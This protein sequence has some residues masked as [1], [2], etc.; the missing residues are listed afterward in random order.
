MS[1]VPEEILPKTSH[2]DLA[3]S[4]ASPVVGI[5][6]QYGM[7]DNALFF[8]GPS[9]TAVESD[10]LFSMTSGTNIFGFGS[11]FSEDSLVFR[12]GFGEKDLFTARFSTGLVNSEQFGGLANA[13]AAIGFGYNQTVFSTL[14]RYG[15]A[16]A[17]QELTITVAASG[18][19][20][21]TIDINGTPFSVP[22]TAGTIQHNALEIADSL[23]AQV[24]LWLFDA[25]DDSG[26]ASVSAMFELAFPITGSFTFSS[27]GTAT[28]AWV[29]IEEGVLPIDIWTAQ[30][31]WSEDTLGALTKSNL[32]SYKISYGPEMA[33]YYIFDASVNDYTLVH[34]EN[35]NNLEETAF[36][37]N[38]T[39]NHSWYALNRFGSVSVTTEG[40]YAGLFRE[41]KERSLAPTASVQS[42]V[43]GIGITPIPIISFRTRGSIDDVVNLANVILTS[44]QMTTTSAKSVT[45]TLIRDPVLTD[46]VFEF[47]D[48]TT[49]ILEIDTSATAVTGTG[50]A[51]AG[52]LEISREDLQEM[53]RRREVLTIAGNVSALPASDFTAT[54]SYAE[55]K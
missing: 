33:K 28:A 15:G 12:P 25:S 2:S 40:G 32:N 54:A 41:G 20:T 24:A 10:S 7:P 50:I 9:G 16:L 11:I 30:A 17:L 1:D 36:I 26:V 19:E 22:L 48:K 5:S 13:N 6:A 42:T 29:E 37:E 45:L 4:E 38:P 51:I 39:F 34:I 18:A 23:N 14:F 49:S 43:L 27:T 55:D 21:A 31:N 8:V 46:P 52:F 47:V 35:V 3:V 44:V 53:I